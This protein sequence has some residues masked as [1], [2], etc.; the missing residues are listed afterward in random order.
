M[1]L[2]CLSS[3]VRFVPA[4]SCLPS[5]DWLWHMQGD[6][7]RHALEDIEIIRQASHND[8]DAGVYRACPQHIDEG[9]VQCVAQVCERIQNGTLA[10]KALSLLSRSIS[11]MPVPSPVPG[12]HTT[13]TGVR[14]PT[15]STYLG[16]IYACCG[17]RLHLPTNVHI[18]TC[19]S[20]VFSCADV[21]L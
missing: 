13:A 19:P 11:R 4:S 5:L 3:G 14:V 20:T 17:V 18:L 10:L 8:R 9:L 7:I 6:I 2:M 15:T 16:A 12:R 21:Q 1:V